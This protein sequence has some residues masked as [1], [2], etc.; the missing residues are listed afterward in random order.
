[1][2]GH[3][4][5]LYCILQ[6]LLRQPATRRLTGLLYPRLL[7]ASQPA[8]QPG[9]LCAKGAQSTGGL[10]YQATLR[11]AALRHARCYV[12]VVRGGFLWGSIQKSVGSLPGRESSCGVPTAKRMTG[13]FC[14]RS[15]SLGLS[16]PLW[17]SASQPKSQFPDFDSRPSCVCKALKDTILRTLLLCKSRVF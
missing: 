12:V 8:T 17:A 7:P 10:L 11:G 5:F 15:A 13:L 2:E 1:M 3:V 9:T 6:I 14:P 4:A 16:G